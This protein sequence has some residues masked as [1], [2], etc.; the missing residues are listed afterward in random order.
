MVELMTR[1]EVHKTTSFFFVYAMDVVSKCITRQDRTV[2][3]GMIKL[4]YIWPLDW[5]F[6][7]INLPADKRLI[8][9][10][11]C[12]GADVMKGAN[13]SVCRF[14][15]IPR[16]GVYVKMLYLIRKRTASSLSSS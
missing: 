10:A 8:G 5:V 6:R 4:S 14:L 9:T 2:R 15:F 11:S 16:L 3:L 1:T 12:P 7:I 13:T